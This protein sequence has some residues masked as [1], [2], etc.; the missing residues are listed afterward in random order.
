MARNFVVYYRVSTD[1]QGRSGLGLDA[2]RAAVEGFANQD[3]GTIIETFTEIETGKGSQPL[4]RRPQ[5]AAAL[6]LAKRRRATLLIAT[7]DRL[8]RNVLFIA[9]LMETGVP[10]VAADMPTAEPFMLHIR[11]AMA[12]EERRMISKRTRVALAAAKRR[13]TVLGANGRKLAKQHQAAAA[14]F[15][16]QLR[17][18]LDQLRADGFTTVRE[19]AAELNAR[20]VPTPNG[21]RWHLRTVHQVTRRLTAPQTAGR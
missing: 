19:L 11:A 15:A 13:G 14:T 10:F 4:I 18:T 2:Q 5:L 1:Q 21:G 8:A 3:G 16:E 6:D 17:P 12:E 7:L 9:G 20:A